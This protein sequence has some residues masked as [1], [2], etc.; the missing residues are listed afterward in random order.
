MARSANF[1]TFFFVGFIGMLIGSVIGK[2]LSDILA[3]P[4][5]TKIIYLNGLAYKMYV[6]IWYTFTLNLVAI[7]G[8]ILAIYIY[9]RI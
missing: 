2:V 8:I 6:Y 1:G 9:K 7:I 5:I 4:V 3:S